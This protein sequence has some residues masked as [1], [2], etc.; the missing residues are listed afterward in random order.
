M[1][2]N[3]RDIGVAKL[4]KTADHLVEVHYAEGCVL[5]NQMLAKVRAARRELMGDAADVLRS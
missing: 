2:S 5:N 1:G 3:E 4:K